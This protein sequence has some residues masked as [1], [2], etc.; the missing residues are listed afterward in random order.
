MNGAASGG[1]AAAA[2]AARSRAVKASGAIVRLA[3]GEFKKLLNTAER[4]LV[5]AAKGG[6]LNR[7]YRYLFAHRGLIFVTLTPDS[8][9]M[10]SGADLIWADRIWIPD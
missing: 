8:I 2:A 5:V 7:K 4:P 3:P 1:A 9:G 6:F 10:P